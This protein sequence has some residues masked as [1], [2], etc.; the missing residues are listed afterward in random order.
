MGSRMSMSREKAAHAADKQ[1]RLSSVTTAIRLLKAFSE[2][3][4]EIGISS[5]AKRLGIAKSTVHRLA[6]TLVSEGMLEQDR[7][8]GKYRL[9]TALFRLG[10]LVRQRMTVSNEGRPYLF[11]LRE[12]TNESVHLAI[13]D[14]L[15]VMYIYNLETTQ[16]VRAQSHIGIRK[17]VYCAAE[18]LAILAFQPAETVDAVI[19]GGLQARTPQTI[20]TA[21]GLLKALETVR[22]RGCA[23]EDEESEIGM[24]CIAAPIR[25]DAGEVVAAVG[26]AGPVSRL[27]K[28]TIAAFIPHVIETADAISSRL[29]YRPGVSR[30]RSS[31]A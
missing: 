3:D 19:R 14:G 8:S 22:Q 1:G 27:S 24:R 12:K 6:V 5:L 2:E 10:A 29:G 18:G 31:A 7:E 17:P 23:I 20:T 9:G 30:K 15:D 4:I 26:L 13:L 28:K 11:Q 16:A 25:D 21:D